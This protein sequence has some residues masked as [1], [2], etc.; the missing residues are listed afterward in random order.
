MPTA[1]MRA[2]RNKDPLGGDR[3]WLA[4]LDWQVERGQQAESGPRP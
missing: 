4:C 3:K 1:S 2:I